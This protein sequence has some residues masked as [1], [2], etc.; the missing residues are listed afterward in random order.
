MFPGR[1]NLN[2]N[3]FSQQAVCDSERV[4]TLFFLERCH[5]NRERKVSF[6]L[7]QLI[8]WWD[9]RFPR[10][11]WLWSLHGV[12]QA[13]MYA[14]AVTI[15]IY[16]ML[17]VRL[18]VLWNV[19]R[20]PSH[21]RVRRSKRWPSVTVTLSPNQNCQVVRSSAIKD[22]TI[23]ICIQCFL[24]VS[25][26]NH[27]KLPVSSFPLA[28]TLVLFP[29]DSEDLTA[30]FS[31]PKSAFTRTSSQYGVLSFSPLA[32]SLGWSRFWQVVKTVVIVRCDPLR[33][34]KENDQIVH[35]FQE[36]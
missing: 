9:F 5:I 18:S 6:L 30:R 33:S 17:G 34:D 36:E 1:K 4:D 20:S 28:S 19:R 16:K 29:P 8:F 23:H 15:S 35:N 12:P 21:W 25:S 22:D 2:T 26:K 3:T 32:L 27:L 10:C 31:L 24:P 11:F 14:S 13:S 7:E